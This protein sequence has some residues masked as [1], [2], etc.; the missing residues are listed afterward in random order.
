MK[1]IFILFL[2]FSLELFAQ[3]PSKFSY[4]FS[5]ITNANLIVSQQKVSV[6]VNILQGNING[7]SVYEEIHQVTTNS[8]GL[9]SIHIGSGASNFGDFSKI[10]WS[11]G[12]YFIKTETDSNGGSNY[13]LLNSNQLL[14]VPFA[15]YAEN[16]IGTKGEK[17]DIGNVGT[18]GLTGDVGLQGVE[19][20]KGFVGNSGDA[21]IKGV[22]GDVGIKGEQGTS[23]FSTGVNKG[24]MFYWTGT[25]WQLIPIG[26]NNGMKLSY[27]DSVPTWLDDQMICRGKISSIDCNAAKLV[28]RLGLGVSS[29]A[30]ISIPVIGEKA[31]LVYYGDFASTGVLG[32]TLQVNGGPLKKGNDTLGMRLYGIPTSSGTAT[33]TILV[34]GK[35]CNINVPVNPYKGYAEDIKDIDGN[36]YKTIYIGD[37]Q[38]MASNLKVSKFR[39]GSAIP[40]LNNVGK[41]GKLYQGQ[42]TGNV[43]PSGWRVP[44]YYEWDILF[45]YLGGKDIA[46]G[47]MKEVGTVNWSSPN[48]GA[49]NTSL[50]TALPEGYLELNKQLLDNGIN[51]YFWYHGAFGFSDGPYMLSSV[52][53][54][55]KNV[56]VD[57]YHSS[58]SIRCIKD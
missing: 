51:A 55:V 6:R 14:S 37:Q 50:F 53:T 52:D 13:T 15:L 39:D 21:G 24:D 40:N 20:P 4:Q 49:T 10:N 23:V 41:Y 30:G 54:K 5:V 47:K 25:S 33:F 48:T 11:L 36:I 9:V 26:V 8:D 18:Q 19:G 38:W 42:A 7:S 31:G 17:G 46:G 27:C 32:L 3:Q 35:T 44:K 34:E 22:Q 12:S 57:I 56:G 58:F 45:T 16:L 2:G 1:Y 43:C 29:T 28:G